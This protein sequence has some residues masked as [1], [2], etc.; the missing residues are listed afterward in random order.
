MILRWTEKKTETETI[1][2]F[3]TLTLQA[4]IIEEAKG[5]FR[6]LWRLEEAD[7]EILE[8]QTLGIRMGKNLRRKIFLLLIKQNHIN[9]KYK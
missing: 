8:A 6:L 7:G 1:D 9:Q 3:P 4:S 5:L 2:F